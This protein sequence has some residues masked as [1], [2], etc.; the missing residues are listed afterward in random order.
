MVKSAIVN[1]GKLAR[2][3]ASLNPSRLSE[4]NCQIGTLVFRMQTSPP[5][6]SFVERNGSRSR[7]DPRAS[8]RASEEEVAGDSSIASSSSRMILAKASSGEP[9]R[10]VVARTLRRRSVSASSSTVLRMKL[11]HHLPSVSAHHGDRDRGSR[12]VDRQPRAGL[13]P[14][15]EVAVAGQ[16]HQGDAFPC[17]DDL[18]VRL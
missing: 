12:Q 11:A 2:S 3:C 13:R 18:V 4:T 15:R 6:T 16:D 1:I 10:R 8:L 5:I 17:G 7:L 14:E 9:N